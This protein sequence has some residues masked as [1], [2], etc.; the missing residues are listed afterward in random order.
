MA[1]RG[2]EGSSIP[3]SS[4]SDGADLDAGEVVG[5]GYGF[6]ADG[7][8]DQLDPGPVL[9]ALAAEA[10]SS[11]LAGLSDDR[12][13]GLLCAWRRLASWAAS[14]EV[15]VISELA[16]R[17]AD[18]GLRAS[19][20]LDDEVAALL[21]LTS[22]A[23]AG[24]TGIASSLA[25]LPQ[26]SKALAAGQ[27]D[28]AKARVIAEETSCLSAE[29][30]ARTETEVLTDAP[31][32]T[33]GQ[34]RVA[35]R[36]AM[37]AAD[38]E[39]AIKRRQQGER[40]ARVE[41]WTEHAGTGALAGRDLPPGEVIAADQRIDALARWLKNNGA[42][43]HLPQ[44]RARVFLALLT[45]QR[46]ETLLP[47]PAGPA[48][49]ADLGRRAPG[50]GG[51]AGWPAGLRGSVNLTVPLATWLGSSNEP[52]QA[53]SV[54]FLDA[55]TCRDLMTSMAANPRSRW[56]VTVTGADGQAVKHGCARE[57]PG[58][59]GT[60]PRQTGPP[61]LRK[62]KFT[63]LASGSCAHLRESGGYRPS[64]ALRHLVNVRDRVCFFPSCRRQAVR[65]DQDHTIPYEEGGRTCE[66]NLAAA[67]R[68]HHRAKQAPGWR[69]GQTQ[70][71]QFTWT[72]PGG[73]QIRTTPGRYPV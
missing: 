37:L 49:D 33:T 50:D 20:H 25:R 12:L 44:L 65:C 60:D 56:C 41:T 30:A 58:P 14:G 31:G 3:G 71:G 43:G 57:G 42:E 10:W 48:G 64:P 67:C 45:G 40:E 17:R 51:A 8:I 38:P 11:G 59:P 27:I 70:P 34:L 1:D 61:W 6:E 62:I 9:A 55:E 72:L 2:P 54:G 29:D 32:Q 69:L 26:T 18:A 21:T 13:A 39:A 68:K 53:A 15:A 5:P 24:L 16:R 63:D 47:S 7:A 36:R 23:A 35:V 28:W 46:P 66:C 19:E 52:G 22:R 4:I 73:R